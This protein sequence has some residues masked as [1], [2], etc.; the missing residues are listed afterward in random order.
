MVDF[1]IP[2]SL[3]TNA[4]WVDQARVMYREALV[5]HDAIFILHGI[6]EYCLLDLLRLMERI[7]RFDIYIRTNE[8]Y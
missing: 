1:F 2:L 6:T 5:A 7:V 3:I 8:A 4:K